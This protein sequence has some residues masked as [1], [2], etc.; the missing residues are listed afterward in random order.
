MLH[1]APPLTSAPSSVR[2][3]VSLP[4]P[5]S[6]T[7]L[8]PHS[9]IVKLRMASLHSSDSSFFDVNIRK[10]PHCPSFPNSLP[11]DMVPNS[12]IHV[13][14]SPSLLASKLSSAPNSRLV[15]KP[16]GALEGRSGAPSIPFITSNS[17][18]FRLFFSILKSC[19]SSF[20]YYLC[21][22]VLPSIDHYPSTRPAMADRGDVA[23]FRHLNP[24]GSADVPQY[25]H[26]VDYT[27]RPAKGNTTGKEVSINLNSYPVLQFPNKTVHQ[28]DVMFNI[29]MAII[30]ED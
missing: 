27:R 25:L 6:F 2:D 22:T 30:W 18:Q 16:L 10:F 4:V 5:P 11:G 7:S 21:T 9:T 12:L 26:N 15:P 24:T 14:C 28:Y 13:H 8:L 19:T 17:P 20:G 23:I 29:I 1:L 3:V